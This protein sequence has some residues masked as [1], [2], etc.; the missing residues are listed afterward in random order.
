VRDD[1]Q[2]H[3][4][5]QARLYSAISLSLRHF[6]SSK[7]KKKITVLRSHNKDLSEIDRKIFLNNVQGNQTKKEHD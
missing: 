4:R 1:R 5:D 2:G 3:P 7:K 6:E